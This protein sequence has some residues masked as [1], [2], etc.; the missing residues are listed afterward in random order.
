MER[1]VVDKKL[2]KGAFGE[3]VAVRKKDS[4]K[5]YAMKIM[6]KQSQAA[7][8]RNWA[9]YIQIEGE[10]MSGLRSDWVRDPDS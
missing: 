3:V 7:M 4:H 2:G 8:S 6:T 5:R 10:V 1:Y 9:T